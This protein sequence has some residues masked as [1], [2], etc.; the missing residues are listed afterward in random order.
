M[1]QLR[2]L[3]NERE[4][5]TW[6]GLLQTYS[7]IVR[8][9]DVQLRVRHDFALT[10]YEVLAQLYLTPERRLRLT[11]LADRLVFTRSGVTRVIDRLER[12]GYVARCGADDDGR[13]VF[14]VLTD[15]GVDR[16]DEV[17]HTFVAVLRE[18]FFDRLREGELEQLDELW[19]RLR[20][21]PLPGQGAAS[22]EA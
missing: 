11:D 17:R 15:S 18:R 13:G 16:F 10:S 5:S 1:R 19:A 3:L 6:R 4:R 9:L 21:R 12:Q 22:P 2:L 8:E 14:A 7:S 20:T